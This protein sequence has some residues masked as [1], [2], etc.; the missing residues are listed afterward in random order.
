MLPVIGVMSAVLNGKRAFYLER[1]A[2][3]LYT[4]LFAHG[5]NALDE[6]LRCFLEAVLIGHHTQSAARFQQFSWL[7]QEIRARRFAHGFVAGGKGFVDE[8]ATSHPLDDNALV[9][10]NLW[11]LPAQIFPEIERQFLEFF[12]ASKDNPKAEFYI[13]TVVN[14]LL[15]EGRATVSVLPNEGQWYGVTYRED[16]DIAQQAFAGFAQQGKYPSPM[17]G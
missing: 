4:G 3:R 5:G 9:S 6:P 8:H 11:G 14:R 2:C 16:K 12:E 10:M 7:Q 17:W 1:V 13:P 15:S